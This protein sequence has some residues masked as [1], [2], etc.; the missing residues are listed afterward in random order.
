MRQTIY[1][2]LGNEILIKTVDIVGHFNVYFSRN[3][4]GEKVRKISKNGNLKI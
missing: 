1:H 2:L 4:N 3:S